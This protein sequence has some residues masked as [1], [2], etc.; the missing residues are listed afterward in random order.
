MGG[1]LLLLTLL[2]LVFSAQAT[3]QIKK[4]SLVQIKKDSKSIET[5]FNLKND[6]ASTDVPATVIANQVARAEFPQ[7]V[8]LI[9]GAGGIYAAFL[10]YGSLQEDVTSF[11]SPSGHSFKQA[12]F[13]M[14]IGF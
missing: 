9:I 11:K 1:L 5:K 4:S 2:C 6:D 12:W 14:A 13:L 7:W 10:Y 3:Q 8:K